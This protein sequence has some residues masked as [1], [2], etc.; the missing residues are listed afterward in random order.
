MKKT[1]V[2]YI[3]KQIVKYV[4]ILFL[5]LFAF[6]KLLGLQFN[7]SLVIEE[8]SLSEL[9]SNR[10]FKYFFGYSPSYVYSIAFLE[11]LLGTFLF[12]RKTERIGLVIVVPYLIHIN[13]INSIFDFN[14]S[15]KIISTLLLIIAI[16]LIAFDWEFFKRF[17]RGNDFL[18]NEK[19]SSNVFFRIRKLKWIFLPSLLVGVYFFMNK[20]ESEGLKKNELYGIWKVIP[21]ETPGNIKEVYFDI[22]SEFAIK[23]SSNKLFKGSITSLDTQRC[24]IKANG[25]YDPKELD[26]FIEEEMKNSGLKEEYYRQIEKSKLIDNYLIKYN[27]EP[28]K[29]T[30]AYKLSGDTL[31]L[32]GENLNQQIDIKLLRKTNR[33]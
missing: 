12:F 22:K 18:G 24:M 23:N 21:S 4:L 17:F 1:M 8:L 9:T 7:V 25:E 32:K 31:H 6:S 5:F 30:L 29:L 10:L 28:Y 15:L 3:I 14:I 20:A 13:L 33:N 11:L 26:H 2:K 19:K 16:L 27:L